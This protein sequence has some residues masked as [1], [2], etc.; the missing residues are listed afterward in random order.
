MKA[1]EHSIKCNK[2]YSTPSII[3]N[4]PKIVCNFVTMDKIISW[5]M[6][7]SG[8]LHSRTFYNDKRSSYVYLEGVTY[9]PSE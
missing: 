6:S 7:D 3:V 1:K 9:N 5:Y 2:T 8:R 4:T